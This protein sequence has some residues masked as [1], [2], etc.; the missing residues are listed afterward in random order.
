MESENLSF[1]GCLIEINS[2]TTILSCTLV[3]VS[4]LT[5]NFNP[6][7][8]FLQ[9]HLISLVIKNPDIQVNLISVHINTEVEKSVFSWFVYI[10]I[11]E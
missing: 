11:T 8:E 4:T 2:L 6:C 10:C 1:Y 9:N 7:S 3:L 5:S